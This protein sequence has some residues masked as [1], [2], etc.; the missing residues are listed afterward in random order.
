MKERNQQRAQNEQ[1]NRELE[2]KRAAQ[3]YYNPD[4]SHFSSNP[5]E[6]RHSQ[7]KFIAEKNPTR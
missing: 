2:V 4:A 1:N 7:L 6:E 5:H 3:Y